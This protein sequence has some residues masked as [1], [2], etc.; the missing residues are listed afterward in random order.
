MKICFHKWLY[1]G[2]GHLE[3]MPNDEKGIQVLLKC[4]KCG[5]EKTICYVEKSQQSENGVMKDE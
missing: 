1:I 4:E 5:K 3:C 2:Y